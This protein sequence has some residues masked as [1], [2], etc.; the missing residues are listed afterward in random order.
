MDSA[1][2]DVLLSATITHNGLMRFDQFFRW[3]HYWGLTTY[4][5]LQPHSRFMQPFTSLRTKELHTWFFLLSSLVYWLIYTILTIDFMVA[6]SP[7]LGTFL[8]HRVFRLIATFFQNYM[9]D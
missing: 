6:S 9:L 7:K 8:L 5:P 2:F 4:H 3:P 1:H